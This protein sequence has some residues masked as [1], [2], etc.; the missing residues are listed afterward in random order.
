MSVCAGDD[1]VDVDAEGGGGGPGGHVFNP[2]LL[3]S[4]MSSC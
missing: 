3:R 4:P 1:D 2:S